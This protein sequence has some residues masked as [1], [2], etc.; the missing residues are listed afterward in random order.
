M[1]EG[2]KDKV[3]WITGASS[4][5][6]EALAYAFSAQ[7]AKVII[8]S[9]REAELQR[10]KNACANP[11]QVQILPLDLTDT[12]GLEAKVPA[13]ISLFGHIDIMVHNGGVTTRGLAVD[14]AID[15]HRH[16]MEL[17]YFSY[18]I[19]TKALLPHFIERKTGHFVVT[20]SVMGKIGTPLRSAYAA[21][22]HALHG[23]FDCLRAEVTKH[24][25][26]VTL[27]TPGYIR[28]NIYLSAVTGD[29][30]VFGDKSEQIDNGL[31]AD[32]AAMQ[33]LKAVKRGAYESYIGKWGEEKLALLVNRLL[34]SLLIKIIPGKEPK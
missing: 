15:V 18:I 25:I 4:G 13:A 21:A 27:L 17:D 28:T 8:S 23:Y 9:R 3:V 6:G 33:I 1:K 11:N 20:S 22:K 19:L 16:V 2:F 10:V 14:T 5:I 7:G 26:K 29:G 24:G 30:K 32:K 12:A 31:P 34:P